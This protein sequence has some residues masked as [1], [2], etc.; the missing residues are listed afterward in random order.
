MTARHELNLKGFTFPELFSPEGLKQLDEKF[1]EFLLQTDD[2]LHGQL[3]ARREGEDFSPPK[4]S[5]LIIQ[6]GPILEAFIAELFDIE[7]SVGYLQAATLLH[8]PIFA[9]KKYYVLRK[10][11]RLVKKADEV[12]DF[13][14][15]DQWV[16]ERLQDKRL[17]NDDRELAV[18][19]WGQQLLE[20]PDVNQTVIEQLVQWCV[21]SFTHK[22]PP[23]C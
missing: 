4:I 16:N 23:M 19:T 21:A 3:I 2:L 9:F 6:C 20:E 14:I 1:L 18:A 17:T 12:S 5:E 11:R 15:L 22:V 13:S 10:A 8:N 7:E